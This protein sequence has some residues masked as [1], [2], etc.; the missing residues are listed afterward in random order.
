MTNWWPYV[1]LAGAML[2]LV[3]IVA[4]LSRTLS[5]ALESETEWGGHLPTVVVNFFSFF[6]ILS[7]VLAVVALALGGI[8]ALRS[9]RRSDVEPGWLALLLAAASTYMI[10][11]GLVYNILLRGIELPQGAT[12]WWSNEILHVVA[13]LLMLADVLFAPR[14]RALPWTGLLAIVAFPIAWAVYTLLR[15]NT[16]VAPATG[17]PWWYPYPFLDPH[18]VAGGYLGVAAYVV[19]IAIAI[20]VAAA[21]V[22]RVG[23]RRGVR[24]S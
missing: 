5:I 7:N 21:G 10:V 17:D 2:T 24:S 16:V 11:T 12:V 18:L 15:A 23:R 3:A 6:T 13:P 14:R 22:V 4:Q 19:G 20:I 1:R 9:R 8:W